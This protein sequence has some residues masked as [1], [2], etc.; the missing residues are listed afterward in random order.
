MNTALDA[1]QLDPLVRRRAIRLGLLLGA[2]CL[3]LTAIFFIIFWFN[4]FPK[5]PVE[6]RR[7]LNRSQSQAEQAGSD[8][9]PTDARPGEPAPH[10]H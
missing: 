2:A 1:D 8:P 9:R 7:L 3:A 6:Y 4:G 10:Q 5:D